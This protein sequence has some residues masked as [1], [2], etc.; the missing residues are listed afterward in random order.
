M[1]NPA[2]VRECAEAGAHRFTRQLKDHFRRQK[3]LRLGP[4][5][6]YPCDPRQRR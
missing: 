4:Y 5:A 6:A 1:L 2:G 3:R